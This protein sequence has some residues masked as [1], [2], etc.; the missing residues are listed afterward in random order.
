MTILTPLLKQ[1]RKVMHLFK[2][3]TELKHFIIE[4]DM[5]KKERK[6]IKKAVRKYEEEESHIAMVIKVRPKEDYSMDMEE[7]KPKHLEE[8]TAQSVKKRERLRTITD[9]G[10]LIE[11]TDGST[12]L[13][14]E[15]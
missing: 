8:Q 1:A 15:E 10:I 12:K 11:Y 2:P 9:D 14:K 13:I 5:T 4:P 6:K 3:P 7:F